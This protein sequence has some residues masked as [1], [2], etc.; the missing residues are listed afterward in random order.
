M[1]DVIELYGDDWCAV[2]FSNHCI[3]QGHS[4]QFSVVM[5]QLVID[6]ESVRSYEQ[7]DV[8]EFGFD[9]GDPDAFPEV[10]DMNTYGD[11]SFN[12]E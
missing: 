5:Q 8:S 10:L 7:Y 12:N 4:V 6:A 9:Y 11:G 1:I 3:Y 2:Y